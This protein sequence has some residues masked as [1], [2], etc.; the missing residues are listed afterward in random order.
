M[1]LPRSL[2]LLLGFISASS[3]LH[4][5]FISA[6][7]R[8]HL[9]FI[10]ASARLR[11]GLGSASARLLQRPFEEYRLLHEFTESSRIYLT[12]H[13]IPFLALGKDLLNCQAGKVLFPREILQRSG[14]FRRGLFSAPGRA[15]PGGF[16]AVREGGVA[17]RKNYI[18]N[19]VVGA[20]R[21]A[22][23]TPNE[24]IGQYKAQEKRKGQKLI[25]ASG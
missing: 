13:G 7:S 16:W 15:A 3:R 4:L 12:V 25:K 1:S 22:S 19:K 18:C 23:H 11:L 6:S 20:A 9:G 10:S 17:G 8:L 21:K 5:G 2:L 14:L 24:F